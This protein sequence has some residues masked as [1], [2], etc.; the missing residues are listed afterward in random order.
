MK[1]KPCCQSLRPWL[2]ANLAKGCCAPLTG[3]DARALDAAV[4]IA[5]LYSYHREPA[6]LEAFGIIVRCM[7]DTTQELAYH[8][9]AHVMDWSDRSRLWHDAGLALSA[10]PRR[11]QA[12]PP[13]WPRAR[14]PLEITELPFSRADGT[15]MCPACSMPYSEHP[16]HPRVTWLRELCDGKLVKL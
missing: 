11:C 6:V 12:E 3:T 5:E 7:Q 16:R 1:P 14:K 10:T 2:E 13:A 9:I 4:H 8:A 15:T